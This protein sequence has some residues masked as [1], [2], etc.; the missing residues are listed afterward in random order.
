[1]S[2][3]KHFFYWLGCLLLLVC[4]MVNVVL[5]QGFVNLVIVLFCCAALFVFGDEYIYYLK[6]CE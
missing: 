1:M 6:R 4:L 2:V 5:Y 3:S